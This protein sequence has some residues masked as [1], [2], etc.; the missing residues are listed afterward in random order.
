MSESIFRYDGEGSEEG[1][2]GWGGDPARVERK[3]HSACARP[4]RF[5]HAKHSFTPF[6]KVP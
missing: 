5:G 2:G 1:A 3:H 4:S 6:P